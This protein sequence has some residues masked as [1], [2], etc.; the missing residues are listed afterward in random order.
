MTAARVYD[1]SPETV[2]CNPVPVPIM[3]LFVSRPAAHQRRN[4]D[5]S[6]VNRS[7][8]S[9]ASAIPSDYN[10]P[11]SD[12]KFRHRASSGTARARRR[13]ASQTDQWQGRCWRVT[14]AGSEA[15]KQKTVI[16]LI[17]LLL[18]VSNYL[19]QYCTTC[20]QLDRCF[21]VF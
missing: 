13:T 15:G 11:V 16:T 14:S 19:M 20:R 2:A 8:V 1:V 5:K 21:I 10:S 9:T 4:C 17:Y 12:R 7:K 3:A 18:N 6:S